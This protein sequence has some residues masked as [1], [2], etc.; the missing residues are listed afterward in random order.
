MSALNVA[1]KRLDASAVAERKIE[2][3]SGLD[4]AVIYLLRHSKKLTLFLKH[5][6]VPIDN[7]VVERALKNR[8]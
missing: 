4:K 2:P 5:P 7:N 1:R 6:G 8:F 3:N